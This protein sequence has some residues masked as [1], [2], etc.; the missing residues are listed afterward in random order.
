MRL[1][2][3]Q[4]FPRCEEKVHEVWQELDRSSRG[5]TT[6]AEFQSICDGFAD[7]QC[8]FSVSLP[9][10]ESRLGPI[11]LLAIRAYQDWTRWLKL[12]RAE[13][14]LEGVRKNLEGIPA[15]ELTAVFEA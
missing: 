2:P 12:R 4:D 6:E 15:A 13:E 11:G 7:V 10:L 8:R 5:T 1:I 14:L 9:I 3:E